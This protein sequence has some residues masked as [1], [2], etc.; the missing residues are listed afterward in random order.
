MRTSLNKL[1]ASPRRSTS[2]SA[3]SANNYLTVSSRGWLA[4]LLKAYLNDLTQARTSR[5][6]R[7][8]RGHVCRADR[9]ILGWCARRAV[10][11]RPHR[12]HRFKQGGRGVS[13]DALIL[14]QDRGAY[15]GRNPSSTG[16]GSLSDMITL[17][18]CHALM[19]MMQESVHTAL[20]SHFGFCGF[21]TA[22]RSITG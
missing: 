5:H 4:A 1:S 20:C 2:S 17:A 16:S 9:A 11:C 8:R 19:M 14:R 22:V 15:D 21:R 7:P 18:C 10:Q 3:E 13:Q 6:P 12:T